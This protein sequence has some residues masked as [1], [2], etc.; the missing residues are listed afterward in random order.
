MRWPFLNQF[1]SHSHI[2]IVPDTVA[3]VWNYRAEIGGQSLA[4]CGSIPS[5]TIGGVRC[6]SLFGGREMPA[7]NDSMNNIDR[8]DADFRK[9][10]F[11]PQLDTIIAIIYSCFT[12]SLCATLMQKFR[13]CRTRTNY[14]AVEAKLLFGIFSTK[15][16]GGGLLNV[17]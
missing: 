6:P 17:R 11:A 5:A 13:F 12:I 15:Y 1:A 4:W 3:H 14:H 10:T 9:A 7:N 16:I 2:R 8:V